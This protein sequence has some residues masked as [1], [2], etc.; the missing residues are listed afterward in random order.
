MTEA[1]KILQ[2]VINKD[3]TMSKDQ[4]TIEAF[5]STLTGSNNPIRQIA[6]VATKSN[7]NMIISAAL[8]LG[9]GLV[10]KNGRLMKNAAS[11]MRNFIDG[12]YKPGI[13][14]IGKSGLL[15]KEGIKGTL[16]GT[17]KLR[18]I[19]IDLAKTQTGLEPAIKQSLDEIIGAK[20]IILKN[21]VNWI[22]GNI[23]GK[24]TDTARASITNLDKKLLGEINNAFA[25]KVRKEGIEAAMKSSLYNVIKPM[26]TYKQ[27]GKASGKG[28]FNLLAKDM[29]IKDYEVLN[30]GL[31]PWKKGLKNALKTG[32]LNVANFKINQLQN[33]VQD[34]MISKQG[35]AAFLAYEKGLMKKGASVKKLQQFF[36]DAGWKPIKDSKNRFSI[37]KGKYEQY[38]TIKKTGKGTTHIQFTPAR[39]GNYHWGGF[40]GNLVFNEKLHKGKVG[41]FGTDVYDVPLD[42]LGKLRPTTLLNVSN[43]KYLKVPTIKSK[44]V[45]KFT[46]RNK[47]N[48]NSYNKKVKEKIVPEL[49]EVKSKKYGIPETKEYSKDVEEY[50]G[51][52]GKSTKDRAHLS[53]YTRATKSWNQDVADY[54]K[55][56][57]SV[58]NGTAT[59]SQILEFN[60]A[61]AKL[62]WDVIGPPVVGTAALAAYSVSDRNED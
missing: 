58:T 13:G 30:T 27:Y 55:H 56:Y 3:Y 22:D 12:Y 19:N 9:A 36:V 48:T 34:I 11:N 33:P 5:R 39:K 59:R 17:R 28:A 62:G 38:I 14:K 46:A 45:P 2:Q 50:F 37:G 25:L 47:V 41:V 61:R 26:A 7:K 44:K 52:F 49:E 15:V 40:N 51:I 31:A 4:G 24:L 20:N 8:M 42:S 32:K 53:Q 1:E 21:K 29:G 18:D 60:K 43:A 16:K 6:D 57:T 23:A 35:K 10:L 54:Y